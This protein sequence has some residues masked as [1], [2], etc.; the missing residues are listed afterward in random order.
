MRKKG[1]AYREFY[2]RLTP[3]QYNFISDYAWQHRQSIASII[4]YLVDK[5]RK[6]K[7]GREKK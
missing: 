3:A 6:E 5:L 7:Y 4:R 1:H 2:I